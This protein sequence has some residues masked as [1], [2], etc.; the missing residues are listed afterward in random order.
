MEIQENDIEIEE[1]K[2]DEPDQKEEEKLSV[3]ADEPKA[4]QDAKQDELTVDKLKKGNEK[5]NVWFDKLKTSI[6]ILKSKCY[7]AVN[8]VI[9]LLKD[10][11]KENLEINKEDESKVKELELQIYAAMQVLSEGN[12]T[13]ASYKQIQEDDDKQICYYEINR[14][15]LLQYTRDKTLGIKKQNDDQNKTLKAELKNI[16]E[17]HSEIK[18][19]VE[20]KEEKLLKTKKK[21][22]Q[23]FDFFDLIEE[24]KFDLVE[25]DPEL[26]T[27]FEDYMNS[28]DAK[29]D[30]KKFYDVQLSVSFGVL[31]Y[32]RTI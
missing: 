2:N 1:N 3:P 18:E 19:E 21:I 32:R 9:H 6:K 25:D 17:S 11:I 14:K 10:S 24:K 27:S 4:D 30:F 13:E 22:N 28:E 5:N 26:P 8:H 12:D 16:V 23:L 7:P 20:K 31:Y 15:E 29:K